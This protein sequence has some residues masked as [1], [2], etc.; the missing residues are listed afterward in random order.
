MSH[1]KEICDNNV[2][3]NVVP[4]FEKIKAKYDHLTVSSLIKVKDKKDQESVYICAPLT[5]CE[6]SCNIV[7]TESEIIESKYREY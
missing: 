3:G 2:T 6:T 7:F 5:M 4:D 1:V